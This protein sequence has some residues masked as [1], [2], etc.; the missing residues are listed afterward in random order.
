MKLIKRNCIIILSVML[1][2]ACA[3][4]STAASIDID[5]Y[6]NE[7]NWMSVTPQILVS[8]SGISNCDVDF[9]TAQVLF[10]EDNNV[11]YIGIEARFNTK[12]D[13]DATDEYSQ[14]VLPQ[15]GVALSVNYGPFIKLINGY[16]DEYD[17]DL[18]SYTADFSLVSGLRMGAE[19]ALGVKMGMDTLESLRVQVIDGNGE[20]SNAYELDLPPLQSELTTV[21]NEPEK[22]TQSQVRTTKNSTTRI[23]TTRPTTTTTGR[24]TTAK[25]ATTLRPST[26]TAA[27]RRTST[28]AFAAISVEAVTTAAPVVITAYI[29]LVQP[30]IFE[31]SG[32]DAVSVQANETTEPVIGGFAGNKIA[33]YLA[34]AALLVITFGVVVVVNMNAEHNE[35]LKKSAAESSEQNK[36]E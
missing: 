14:P 23:T 10:D 16:T 28:S 30:Q 22:A 8:A 15:Y 32:T 11:A 5:G 29:T 35:Q 1:I 2:L 6:V 25:P 18:F 20:P 27:E 4:N 24:Y 21:T 36:N 26:V 3:V 34:V 13:E 31:T 12:V 19:I 9:A 7:R 33:A 17:L